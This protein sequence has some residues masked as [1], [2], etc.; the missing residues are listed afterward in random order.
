MAKGKEL[1]NTKWASVTMYVRDLA[2]FAC[3]LLATTQ[4]TFAISW[5]RIQEIFFCQLGGITGN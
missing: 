2:E 3:V 4:M 5:L 1:D